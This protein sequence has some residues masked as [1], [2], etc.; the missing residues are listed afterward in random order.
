MINI[1]KRSA[2][3]LHFPKRNR[4][5]TLLEVM[6]GLSLLLIASSAIGWKTHSF[7][8]KRRFATDIQ[9]IQSRCLVLYR[10]AVNAEV[11]WKGIFRKEGNRWIFDSVC[12]DPSRKTKFSPIYFQAHKIVHNE[13]EINSLELSFF[14]SAQVTPCGEILFLQHAGSPPVVW[15]IPAFFGLASGDGANQK[16]SLH[17]K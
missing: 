16:G 13:R 11:D 1:R 14:S 12:L 10:M 9:R 8:K 3:K 6:I 17:P 15:K 7:V 5:F 4:F 2:Q